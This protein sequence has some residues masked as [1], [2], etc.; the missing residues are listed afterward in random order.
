MSTQPSHRPSRFEENP[1][2][3]VGGDLKDGIPL[4]TGVPVKAYF[5]CAGMARIRLR[6]LLTCNATAA[7][8]FLRSIP[9]RNIEYAAEQPVDTPIVAGVE[10]VIDVA[11]HYGEG[12]ASLEIT[13]LQNGEVVYVDQ[14]MT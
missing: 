1:P 8:R 12:R 3:S 14:S 9:N 13:P 10:S 5:N 11:A 4:A 6:I 2:G 7:F